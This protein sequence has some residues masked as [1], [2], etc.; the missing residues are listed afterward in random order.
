M[1]VSSDIKAGAAYVELFIEDNKLVR[2]VNAAKKKLE[3]FGKSATEI[4][5]KLMEAGAVA[6]APFLGGIK[7]FSDFQ[8]EMAMVSTALEKPD[9]WMDDFSEGIRRMSVDFGEST[10]VL[11]K[12]LHS[13]LE[14]SVPPQEAMNVLGVSAKA[15][16]GGLTDVG[17]AAEAITTVLNA[18]G[19]SA[20]N[21]ADV[22]DWLFTIA[23]KGH[24]SFAELATS[25]G[26]IAGLAGTVGF[27]MEELG[28]AISSMT[29]KGMK[30]EGAINTVQGVILSFISPSKDAAEAAR[31]L[32]FE[33]SS[34]TL[35]SEGLAGIFERL[36]SLPP[37]TISKL[38][39]D[40]VLKGLL[41]L[42]RNMGDFRNNIDAMNK[43]AGTTETAYAKMANTLSMSFA[44]LKQAGLEILNVLGETL[45]KPIQKVAEITLGYLKAVIEWI[46]Q[47]KRLVLT[48]ALVAGAVGTLGAILLGAA[49][50]AKALAVIFAL[51]SGVFSVA[52]AAVGIIG[53]IIAAIAT[54]VG[55]T[56]VAVTA[57]GAAI[58]YFT[59]L[60]GKALAWL[61]E[62]FQLL[63]AFALESWKG[64]SD[65]LLAGDFQLAAQILWLSLKVAWLEGINYLKSLWISF[66]AWYNE[67]TNE[68]FYGAMSIIIDAWAE[69]KTA[70]SDTVSFLADIW[71]I[72]LNNLKGAWNT[73]QAW[74][75]K[76]WADI[77]HVFDKTIDVKMMYKMIDEEKAGKDTENQKAFDEEI[78]NSAA[79]ANKS[80]ATIEADRKFNQEQIAN[81]LQGDTQENNAEKNEALAKSAAA[82]EA[83]KAEWRDAIDKAHALT[84]K[85]PK[86]KEIGDKLKDAQVN[87]DAFKS[88]YAASGSFYA[89]A[90]L[91]LSAL[92]GGGAAERTAKASEDT[93]KNTKDMKRKMEEAWPLQFS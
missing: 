5:K 91:S 74:L 88:S 42:L 53:S 81:N 28:A 49:I 22:S 78:N 27:S 63:K 8:D 79:K 71:N 36:K 80:K 35:K 43:R 6:G 19:L 18:Y 38:F 7:V 12:G 4:G 68:T 58:L 64:I 47:N 90:A 50:A 37:E 65:A 40:K 62:K 73:S 45:S 51:L 24:T 52:S 1:S 83:A 10:G 70:W 75:Q 9:S 20:S 25:I 11:A 54:P 56:V 13:I 92:S 23:K 15:A 69:L 72:F 31:S 87:V 93:A 76:R 67:V 86:E 34:A 66:K 3:T 57:L 39:S 30:T 55:I 44:R 61:G 17:T 32:G 84:E 77:F 82:L 21:A 89:Q 48:V 26:P 41:P 14:A 33:M 29:K 85:T 59:G 16:K 2:G 60:G 46:S